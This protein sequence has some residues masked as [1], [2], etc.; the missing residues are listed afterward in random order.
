MF[1]YYALDSTNY[2]IMVYAFEISL[3][4][5]LFFRLV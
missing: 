4:L 2:F 1:V 3:K 5:H